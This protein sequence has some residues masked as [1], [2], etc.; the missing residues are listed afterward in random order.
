[1]PEEV[2]ILMR[3]EL[4]CQILNNLFTNSQQKK[5]LNKRW[6]VMLPGNSIKPFY[7]IP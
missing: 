7:F 4:S 5:K 1:M 2:C 3:S 6:E